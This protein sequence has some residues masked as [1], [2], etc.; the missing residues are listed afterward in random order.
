MYVCHDFIHPCAFSVEGHF[1]PEI[2]LFAFA[3]I[4][5]YVLMFCS[6]TDHLYVQLSELVTNFFVS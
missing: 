5:F 1:C 2:N 4:F 3:F 6:Y